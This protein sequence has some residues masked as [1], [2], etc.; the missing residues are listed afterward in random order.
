[1]KKKAIWIQNW[2]NAGE[3]SRS[4]I[5]IAENQIYGKE[6]AFRGGGRKITWKAEETDK[7]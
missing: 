5:N 7:R 6:P 1:M 3:T 2:K 4:R